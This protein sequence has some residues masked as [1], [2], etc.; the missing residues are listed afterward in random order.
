MP[1][2]GDLDLAVLMYYHP[3][4][5]S[6]YAEHLS[7]LSVKAPDLKVFDHHS[8]TTLMDVLHSSGIKMFDF[9]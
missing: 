1:T 9:S 8:Y 7:I 3:V 4:C 6:Q 2:R 5:F